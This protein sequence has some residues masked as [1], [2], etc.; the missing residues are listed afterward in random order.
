MGD[1]TKL[2][3]TLVDGNAHGR[4]CVTTSDPQVVPSKLSDLS[5]RSDHHNFPL[6]KPAV[7]SRQSPVSSRLLP[8]PTLK[9]SRSILLLPLAPSKKKRNHSH[10]GGSA[11]FNYPHQTATR[12][13]IPNL[14][15][16]A[17]HDSPTVVNQ[18]FGNMM[19]PFWTP[20]GVAQKGSKPVFD[21]R[22][23]LQSKALG[24]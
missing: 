11:I 6:I 4:R 13:C 8:S 17:S 5:R 9:A 18:D 16:A 1:I 14:Y 23:H 12:F 3:G 2:R 24:N 7:A 22:T 21:T 15:E 10:F 20:I 19:D